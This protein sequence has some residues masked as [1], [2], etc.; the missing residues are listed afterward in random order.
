[1]VANHIHVLTTKRPW[2]KEE[3]DAW[4]TGMDDNELSCDVVKAMFS[5]EEYNELHQFHAAKAFNGYI[6]NLVKASQEKAKSRF[7][8][9]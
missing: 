4:V 8:K 6:D 9:S 5:A 1:M 7:G 2:Q 3:I